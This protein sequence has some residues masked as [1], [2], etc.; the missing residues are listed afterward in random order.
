MAAR[1]DKALT[2]LH[3]ITSR[4][5]VKTFNLNPK[6]RFDLLASATGMQDAELIV[7]GRLLKMQ[8]K[9][10]KRGESLFDG[11]RAFLKKSASLGMC[12][13]QAVLW[14]NKV[15]VTIDQAKQ[16]KN[17][18]SRGKI[19]EIVR[20]RAKQICPKSLIKARKA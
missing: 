3:K 18:A 2:L 1:D 12:Q 15:G 10:I 11:A 4:K 7:R 6:S 20:F 13:E 19:N 17:L 16:F 14:A 9:L 5:I 8:A